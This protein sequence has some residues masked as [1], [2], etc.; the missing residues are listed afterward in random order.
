M[1]NHLITFSVA[2]LISLSACSRN[3]NELQ[4]SIS[5][6]VTNP[7]DEVRKDAFISLE[8]KELKKLAA[9]FNGNAFEV[10][11]NNRELASQLEDKDLDGKSDVISFVTDLKP[12]ETKEIQIKYSKTGEVKHNY[13]N[14]TYAELGIK[15]DYELT[16][17]KYTGGR[18]ENV[19]S[20]RVPNDHVDHNAL[21]KYEGPG[22]ESEKVGYR[23]YLDWRNAH[24]IFGKKVNDLI[25]SE[26]GKNDLGWENHS[27]HEM[28]E[29]GMDIFKVGNS[30]GI[31]SIAT[32]YNNQ[33]EKIS[34]TDSIYWELLSN[35]PVKSEF[36]TSYYG[37]LVGENNVDLYSRISITAGSRLTEVNLIISNDLENIV[38][39]LAKHEGVEFMSSSNEE[40][41]Q[42]ISLYGKQSLAG[43]NLGIALFYKKDDLIKFSEDDLNYFVELKPKENKVKYCFAAAWEQEPNGIESKDEFI[44]Y[45]NETISGLNNPVIVSYK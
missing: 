34:K 24:D 15:T 27:Y 37:W 30:L 12:N 36:Q 8:I 13:K 4:E 2:I 22:W 45:L 23:F 32:L 3:D 18:F 21:F 17:G 6:K 7:I 14:R 5:L 28:A 40:G 16:E 19:S 10:F 43:D 11:D 1:R 25:I 20:F 9:D 29:W 35:G 33:I 39:G 42:Y 26:V 44:D 31:G 41:W 38:T